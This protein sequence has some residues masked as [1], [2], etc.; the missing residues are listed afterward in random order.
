MI[1]TNNGID[2]VYT[3]CHMIIDGKPKY[4]CTEEDLK[5][6]GYYPY[7]IVYGEGKDGLYDGKWYHYEPL[8]IFEDIE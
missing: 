3:G 1:L 6:N 8:I 4:F 2:F 5:N 7:I